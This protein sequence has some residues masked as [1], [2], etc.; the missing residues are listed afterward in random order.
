MNMSKPGAQ[1]YYDSI[2]RLY[3]SWGVDDMHWMDPH[4]ED[5]LMDAEACLDCLQR[6]SFGLRICR[7][8]DEELQQHHGCK[9]HER[10]PR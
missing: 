8:D 2:A 1:A 5:A 6:A 9:E 7:K 3:E 4:G 10:R